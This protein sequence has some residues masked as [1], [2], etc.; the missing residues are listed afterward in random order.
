MITMKT[1]LL[2]LLFVFTQQLV[3]AQFN[4]STHYLIGYT[5]TGVINKTNNNRSYVLNNGIRFTLNRQ[6]ASLNAASSWVYG[7]QQAT[8]T[9]NDFSSTVDFDLYKNIRQLYYWG[10]GNYDRSYSLKVNNRLQAG[11]GLGYSIFRDQNANLVI[12]DGI[13]YERSDLTDANSKQDV[14]ETLRNS[15]RV[16]FRWVI[17]D[18]I[19]LDGMH[20]LQNS[21]S[22]NDDYIIKSNTN[23]SLKLRKWLNFTT[24]LTYNKITRTNRENLLFTF[25][26]TAERYF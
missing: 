11:A 24:S 1:L 20:F 26:L 10:I 8:K 25:G 6:Q 4:D 22:I 15:L 18:F 21:L 9:N 3:H 2:I 19:T 7:Q 14:Y 13:I 23:F 16:K 5:S 12:S 17:K